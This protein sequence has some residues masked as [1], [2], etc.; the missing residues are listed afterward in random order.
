MLG[1]A[2]SGPPGYSSEEKD[3]AINEI[4]LYNEN[5]K[6]LAGRLKLAKIL[7]QKKFDCAILLQNAFDAA[8]IA[9]LAKIPEIIGYKRDCRSFL[10]TKAIPVR[11]RSIAELLP[12][13]SPLMR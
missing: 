12:E 8:L 7:R 3:P 1:I 10:L 2:L 4:I 11:P 5:F 6:G 13:L 9:W